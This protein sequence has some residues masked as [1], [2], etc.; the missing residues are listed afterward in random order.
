MSELVSTADAVKE[1]GVTGLLALIAIVE[2]VVIHKLTRLYLKCQ[3][4]R[5][6]DMEK[7]S[8]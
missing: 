7:H 1:L 2:G 6:S 4:D 8:S 5:I 3:A